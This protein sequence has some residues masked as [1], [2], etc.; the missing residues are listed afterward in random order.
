MSES[1]ADGG[2]PSAVPESSQDS[3]SEPTESSVQLDR[4]RSRSPTPQ[5]PRHEIPIVWSMDFNDPTADVILI[6]SDNS[7]FRVHSW[8]LKKHRYMMYLSESVTPPRPAFFSSEL[9]NNLVSLPS[10]SMLSEAPNATQASSYT[11]TK[12]V[13][14]VYGASETYDR[15]AIWFLYELLQLARLLESP[16]TENLALTRIKGRTAKNAWDIFDVASMLQDVS[17]GKKAIQA[18]SNQKHDSWAPYNRIHNPNPSSLRRVDP[19]WW[20]ELIRLRQGGEERRLKDRDDAKW[21]DGYILVPWDKV[22]DDFT[23]KKFGRKG[24]YE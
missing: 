1:P 22:A 24:E 16:R 13:R 23:G 10:H 17:M 20:I 12:F 19:Y 3:E 2:Q 4:V 9:I 6:A 8:F 18:P 14:F 7:H 21:G 11:F 15:E 5:P